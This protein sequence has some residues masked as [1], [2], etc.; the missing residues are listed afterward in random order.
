MDIFKDEGVVS[1]EEIEGDALHSDLMD[2][3]VSFGP[4]VDLL[5]VIKDFNDKVIIMS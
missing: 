5:D 4:S 2:W 3:V 1:V